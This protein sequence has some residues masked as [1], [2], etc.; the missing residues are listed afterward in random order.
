LTALTPLRIFWVVGFLA[1]VVQQGVAQQHRFGSWNSVNV[2]HDL[3]KRWRVQVGETVRYYP[4]PVYDTQWLTD[5]GL[6]RE[7][8]KHVTVTPSYRLTV[9]PSNVAHRAYVDVAYQV[10]PKK[11]QITDRVRYQYQWDREGNSQYLRNKLTVKYRKPKKFTPVVAAELFYR[12]GY[13]YNFADAFR[14]FAGTE[15]KLNKRWSLDAEWMHERE[16]Q[17][18]NP[19]TTDALQLGL[20]YE[21]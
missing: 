3:S 18:R 5:V 9:Q 2:Q 13:A 6:Q 20:N 12:L 16:I 11:F 10:R 15:Y 19:L 17:V 7:L 21:F 14:L 1:T 4:V 8:G